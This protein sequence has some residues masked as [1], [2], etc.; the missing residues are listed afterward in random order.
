MIS[1]LIRFALPSLL[2]LMLAIST[3]EKKVPRF[4]PVMVQF[5]EQDRL[6]PPPKN[7]ILFV[8]S[9]SI[10]VWHDLEEQF[11]DLP[12]IERGFGGSHMS[13]LLRYA[14]R[15]VIPY[16]PRLV[17][18]YEGDNDIAAGKPPER[19]AGQFQKLIER[20][21]EE[22]PEARFAFISIKP[23]G[24][25]REFMPVMDEA[26]RLIQEIAAQDAGVS[27]VDVWTPMLDERGE[28]RHEL[29]L[30]DSLHLNQEGYELWRQV[31]APHLYEMVDSTFVLDGVASA[32][33]EQLRT[34]WGFKVGS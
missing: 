14:S 12:I 8:G 33:V 21:R 28:P 2:V 9:S 13:D 16:E 18:V 11:S 32:R 5:E 1:H 19:V 25:R 26:N 34:A 10:R 15:I 4:E 6:N 22:V 31:I 27:Y 7:A 17:V 29:F 3:T 24:D 20:V 30:E 23:S